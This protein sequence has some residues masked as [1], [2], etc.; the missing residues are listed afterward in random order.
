MQTIEL[1]E[2]NTDRIVEEQ[3]ALQQAAGLDVIDQETY[4]QAAE[5]TK[6]V[7]SL[8]KEVDSEFNEPVNQAHKLH[9]TLLAKKAKYADPL[10][11]L[12]KDLKSKMTRWYVAEEQRRREEER[13]AQEE[14]ERQAEELRKLGIDDAAD[15]VQSSPTEVAE[16]DKFGISYQTYYSFE[17]TDPAL[18]PREYLTVD[19]VKIGQ[20]VRA[21]K[22][23]ANIP[24][25]KVVEEKRSVVR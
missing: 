9:K 17:I 2:V 23:Q 1:I 22:D 15:E 4:N 12:E 24:G 19:T 20:V 5:L 7:K 11:K 16:I 8:L 25:V 14:Q 6:A 10:K 13:K 3:S 18:I 21:L